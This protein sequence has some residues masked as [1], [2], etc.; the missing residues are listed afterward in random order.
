MR[1]AI[2]CGLMLGAL[3]FL[4]GTRPQKSKVLILG[5]ARKIVATAES[6]AARTHL[7]NVVGDHD[8]NLDMARPMKTT[9]ARLK[10]IYAF[11]LA[12]H[13]VP[14]RFESTGG[15]PRGGA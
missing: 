11:W 10:S 12:G 2:V 9:A 1:I 4:N 14:A 3:A 8:G 5:T 6:E 7:A 15:P 13:C